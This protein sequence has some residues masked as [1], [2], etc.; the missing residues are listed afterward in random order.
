MADLNLRAADEIERLRGLLRDVREFIVPGSKI[1]A[2]IV[3]ALSVA[4]Q[5]STTLDAK[6]LHHEA[7]I[8]GMDV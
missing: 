5:Q 3:A 4:D 2:R 1:D 8:R 7:A 6:L